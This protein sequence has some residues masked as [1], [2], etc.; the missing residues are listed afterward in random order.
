ARKGIFIDIFPLDRIPLDT[1]QQ[2]E[3]MTKF[4]LLN[5]R[6]LF[7]LRYHLVDNPLRKL[8]SPLSPEQLADVKALKAQ[9]Q[10]LMTTYQGDTSLRQVKNLASQYAYNKEVYTVAEVSD[11]TPMPFEHLTVQVPKMYSSILTRMYGDYM[12]LPPENQR[13]EKHLEKVIMDNQVFTQ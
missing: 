7:Q 6:I 3:Q 4:Q 10:A 11:L 13:T 8:Q 2:R 5:T 1:G 9:R 12:T